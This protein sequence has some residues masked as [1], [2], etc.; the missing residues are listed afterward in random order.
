[1]LR[2]SDMEIRGA[3]ETMQR[4]PSCG[5][6]IDVANADPLARVACPQ[7]GEKV[8]VERAFDNFL[9]VETLGVG[10]MGSVYKAKDTRLGRFVALK[11]LRSDLSADPSEAA[12]LE[13]EARLTAAVN[14]PNIVQVFSSGNAHGQF[15]IVMELVDHGSLDDLMAQH[16]R[17]PEAQVLD[18][19]IQ[20][21]EGLRAA[22][23][24]GLIHRDIKPANILFADERT[25]KIGDFGLAVAAE[26]TAEARNEIWGTPYYV[27]PERLDS[28][29]EDLRS[30]IYSLG[31][32]L[33]HAVA[34]RPPISGES[35][36]ASELRAL[37]AKPV[38]LRSVAPTVSK[39][40]AKAIDRMIAPD[41]RVR[42]QGYDE[43]IASL[44][45]ARA[46]LRGERSGRMTTGAW[47]AAAIVVLAL[48][49]GGFFVTKNARKSLPAQTTGDGEA[50][51]LLNRSFEEAR[52]QL[53]AG[54]TEA[55]R[56]EFGRL[57]GQAKDRQPLLNWLRL[58]RGLAAMQR[59]FG[60]QARQAFQE[61][62]TAGP[63]ATKGSD[64]DLARFFVTT[65]QT[66]AGPAVVRPSDVAQTDGRGAD[67]FAL[68]LFAMKD[69]WQSDFD[70][71][72]ALLE[73]FSATQPSG[74]VSWIAEYKP[75]AQ[76]YLADYRVYADWK[77]AAGGGV[78]SPEALARSLAS[79]R[80]AL[81]KLQMHGPMTDALKVEEAALAKREADA[82]KT[83]NAQRDLQ[84][85]ELQQKESPQWEATLAAYRAKLEACDF[86]GAQEAVG[87]ASFSS[88]ELKAK[89]EALVKKARWLVEWQKR[90]IADV[91]AKQYRANVAD[92]SGMRY[93]GF[94]SAD[95]ASI[96][97]TA[98]AYGQA[99]RPWKNFSPTTLLA[100]STSFIQPGAPD[101][102]DREWRCAIYASETG[103]T[104]AARKLAESAAAARP[105]YRD[106]L[107][108]LAPAR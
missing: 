67:A 64:A 12:R 91:N 94:S 44:H 87:A 83:V 97:A 52:R 39:L 60:T 46:V 23:A 90:F 55:A 18:V 9:I 33:F 65:A 103:Q 31:A 85:K 20:I 86:A 50:T 4:C 27:A 101:A 47:I 107:K 59:G 78:D 11:L 10:G 69:W 84:A 58:H 105:E 57:A 76:K 70:D 24:K 35:N 5:T 1:M 48:V 92:V 43:V 106:D 7:C 40:T 22:N 53:I 82:Q 26:Q 100:A 54:K 80:A 28:Q 88:P 41:P 13:Q 37:K 45:R 29:P 81:G 3:D 8:R 102:A 79:T 21:A 93:S 89:H 71:A 73:R 34:G 17:I 66:M 63:Y 72:A 15:Y 96:G 30:D 38:P 68:F 49:A 98:G 61:I 56:N 104:D 16:E 51:A 36:S 2:L 14:H 62:A 75:L 42:F 6:M 95:A 74:T 25:A 32:T 108:L 77:K 19:G 99:R